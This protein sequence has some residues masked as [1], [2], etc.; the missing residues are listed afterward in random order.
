MKICTA[1]KNI[2]PKQSFGKDIYRPDAKS[3]YCKK[4]KLDIKKA[5]QKRLFA[6]RRES[7][8]KIPKSKTC[9]SCK[10]VLTSENFSK[11]I[12]QHDGLFG[13]CKPCHRVWRLRSH[14]KLSPN[15]ITEMLTLQ[16]N[17]QTKCLICNRKN[18]SLVIDHDHKTGK[19]RG[20]LCSPCNTGLGFFKDNK[21]TL[22]NAISYLTM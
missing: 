12:V 1:C 20:L 21:E 5:A 2:L 6:K 3:I 19:V 18:V 13:W 15:E 16:N 4:C 10:K 9:C 22:G 11:S 14:Y 7:P 8:P 17:P